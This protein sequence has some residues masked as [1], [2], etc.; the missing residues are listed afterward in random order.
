[1]LKTF[2]TLNIST[3]VLKSVEWYKFIVLKLYG[4][5]GIDFV[6]LPGCSCSESIG[7]MQ[8]LYEFPTLCL[9]SSS[10]MDKR[11]HNTMYTRHYILN[12]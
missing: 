6:E 3:D 10:C 8:D 12:Q 7:I 4:T 11:L 2:G 1:M 5:S 9:H